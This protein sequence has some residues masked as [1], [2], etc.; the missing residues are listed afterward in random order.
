MET[1]NTARES[2]ME[3]SKHVN[4]L[5]VDDRMENLV[6]LEAALADLEVNFVKAQSGK[7]ALKHLLEKEFAVILLDV[8]MPAIRFLSS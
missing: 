3:N 2:E 4:I 7:E 6:A 5:M 8:Q 1:K